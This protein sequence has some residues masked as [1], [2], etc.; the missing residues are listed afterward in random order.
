M[1][2]ACEQFELLRRGEGKIMLGKIMGRRLSAA[3]AKEILLNMR[4]LYR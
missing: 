1:L 3:F 4:D 2:A